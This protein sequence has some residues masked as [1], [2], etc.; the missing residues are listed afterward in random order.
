L[1]KRLLSSYILIILVTVGILGVMINVITEQT[2][3][4]YVVDQ[5]QMHGK[6][7]PIM[8][9][10]HYSRH[11]S[12]KGVQD[13]IEEADDMIG[14]AVTLVDKD[15]IIVASTYRERIHQTIED[16]EALGIRIPITD[17]N[18]KL[19]G[20]VYIERYPNQQRADEAFISQLNMGLLFAGMVVIAGA[21]IL[22]WFLA[23]SFSE[24]LVEMS[25]AASQISRGNYNIRMTQKGSDEMITLKKAFH[26]MAEGM[27]KVEERRR[28]LIADVS[29]EM[30]T[31][32]T[33][34]QGYLESL[35]Y[36]NILDRLSAEKAFKAMHKEVKHLLN[37]V[38]DLRDL[39]VIDAGVT[40][41]HIQ[42]CSMEEVIQDV[43]VR[44]EPL[45]DEKQIQL[46]RLFGD[47]ILSVPIDRERINQVL[48]NMLNNALQHTP[49]K[50]KIS[51]RHES[52]KT[53]YQL[54]IEDNGKGIP[55]EHIP[56]IFERFYRVDKARSHKKNEGAG[57]GLSIV[58][59]IIEAHHGTIDVKSEVN[60]GTK[61]MITLPMTQEKTRNL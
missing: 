49:A 46:E 16:D 45:L 59:S 42:R 7:L 2:F 21:I 60:K 10:S 15:R 30:R 17:Q 6:M 35:R 34:I 44:M 3:S 26:Q 8:L 18:E 13:S 36:G 33:V 50:G 24:P 47:R 20:T 56:F 22:G 11:G 40:K 4:R 48:Y 9:S 19:F 58:R 25:A 28:K 57:I 14:A 38:E 43:L 23:R 61:F 52:D 27:K 12:W 41:L 51:I 29:H 1:F 54:I 37:V 32:L 53:N 39:S 5:T 55:P 31:P